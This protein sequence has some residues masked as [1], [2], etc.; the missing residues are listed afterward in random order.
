MM[1]TIKISFSSAARDASIIAEKKDLVRQLADRKPFMEHLLHQLEDMNT[2]DPE[3]IS[4]I[5][6]MK[7]SLKCTLARMS[8]VL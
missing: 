1:S 2:E 7:T 3:Q 5:A 6:E 4:S 8:Q